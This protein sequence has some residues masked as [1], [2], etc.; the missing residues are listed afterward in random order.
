MTLKKEELAAYL[1]HTNLQAN[2]TKE[3]IQQTCEEA[4]EFNTAAVCVNSYW[5]SFVKE[6]LA[7]TDIKTCVVV[8]F[9]LGAM[10]TEAK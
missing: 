4:K 5:A 10:T 7:D 1:D 6:R 8:G 9:P 2:A 3:Q